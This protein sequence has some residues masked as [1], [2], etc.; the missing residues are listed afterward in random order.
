MVECT[1]L[2]PD[3]YSLRLNTEE[4]IRLKTVVTEGSVPVRSTGLAPG[5]SWLRRIR[6]YELSIPSQA[7]GYLALAL[8][9]LEAIPSRFTAADFSTE[10]TERLRASED[11]TPFLLVFQRTDRAPRND[12]I[13]GIEDLVEPVGG[14]SPSLNAGPPETRAILR[15]D[16]QYRFTWTIDRRDFPGAEW[17]QLETLP[18]E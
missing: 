18:C 14:P 9:A 1:V 17:F 13:E 8:E 11:Q 5:A 12:E 2:L 15:G 4:G 7:M 6:V 10:E 3:L 16:A